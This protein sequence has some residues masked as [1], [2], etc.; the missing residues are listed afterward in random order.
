MAYHYDLTCAEFDMILRGPAEARDSTEY[1]RVQA[2]MDYTKLKEMQRRA[3]ED[4][5]QAQL[6]EEF[7]K[8]K[9]IKCP[10]PACGWQIE[11]TGGCHHMSCEPTL[12]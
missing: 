1:E 11:R 8:R 7:I 3:E 2:K 10:E 4:Q 6:S 5:R 9:T 12:L